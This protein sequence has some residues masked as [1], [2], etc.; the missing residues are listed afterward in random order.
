M[1]FHRFGHTGRCNVGIANS[2]DFEHIVSIS[3]SVKGCVD[4]FEQGKDL[5]RL[6]GR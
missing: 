4:S 3:Y 5:L 6:S 2:F 1:L